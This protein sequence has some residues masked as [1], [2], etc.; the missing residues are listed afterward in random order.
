MKK[1]LIVD[2][3]E[4]NRYLMEVVLKGCGWE[5]VTTVNGVEALA[6]AR[7]DP[8]DIVISDILMP[9]MDGFTL[10]REWKADEV[11][12]HIPFVFYTATYTDSRDETFALSLGADRFIR[13]PQEP[14]LF[15]KIIKEVLGERYTTASGPLGADMEIFRQ[16]NEVL[17]RKL[18]KKV[19]DLESA[20]R[21]LKKWEE[22]YRLEFE[23]INDVIILLD[24]GLNI[25]SIS[26][27]LERMLGYGP[28]DF[29][30]RPISDLGN[31]V[32][33][34]VFAR[35]VADMNSILTGVRVPTTSC[36]F[37]AR[38]GTVRYGEISGSP[39]V[40]DG[41]IVGLIA[42]VR[43]ITERKQAEEALLRTNEL[44]DSIVENIPDMI[45]LKDAHDLRF[46]RFNRA[47][48]ELLGYSRD[49][50]LGKNDY[51][52]FSPEQADFFTE[53]DRRVLQGKRVVDI[54]EEPIRT[55]HRGE[56][57]LHTKKVP[58]LAADA[59][60]LYLLGISE[61]ITERKRALEA[62]AES[63]EKFRKAFNTT[64]DAVNINRLEDGLYVSINPGFTRITG[65]TEEDIIGR[66]SIECNIWVR[67]E[68]R[69]RLVEGLLKDGEVSNLEAVFRMKNG[70]IRSGLM[71]ASMIELNGV[72]HILNIT[73]DI[74][75]FMDM[76]RK[77]IHAQ[78]MEAIGTMAGGIAHDFNNVLMG[79]Q[80]YVSLI[81][82]NMNPAD[83]N[84]E[85]LRKI[86][87]QVQS[88]AGLSRQLLGFARGG[89]YELKP[90]NINEIIEKTVSIFS[91]TRKEIVMRRILTPDIWSV[92]VDRVQMEQ[93]FM[94][95]Y[96]N[97]W[98]AMPKG[99]EISLRTENF[100]V[101]DRQGERGVMIPGRYVKIEIADSGSGMDD[102]TR[103]RIFD[104]F[105][106][107]KDMGRGTGLGLAIVYGIIKAHK[108][109]V[110][111][112]SAPGQGTTFTVYLPASGKE[113][114]GETAPTETIAGG[115]E[116]ILLVDDEQMILEVSRELL[117][118]LGY[119]VYAAAGG[120]EAIALYRER[121]DEIDLVIL[122]MIM[123]GL[124]GG[125]T[126]DR[127][128]EINPDIKVL[129]ASGYSVSGEAEQILARGCNGFLQK[130]FQIEKL[131]RKIREV[132]GTAD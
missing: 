52:F 14:E 63:E 110:D 79:I 33:S 103:E 69:K 38:D 30:G 7:R 11:L 16:Y 10:C 4:Q 116:T 36:E 93:V 57:I 78:K 100:L 112:V 126:F 39:I 26:P 122:D 128:H 84:Y 121:K 65:Y 60:P 35:V 106:T 124:S 85:R 49:E 131:S 19:G 20:N 82:M 27:S 50:L 37:I 15:V 89:I 97:S 40:R 111:V 80:G 3:E 90:T 61:D 2:D 127:L 41:V 74:T 81:L 119:R 98:Q 6:S 47:G 64:P 109:V 43:D 101:E 46:V 95:L 5:T 58:I 32:R 23:N 56:R 125:E 88:G 76:E 24:T 9:G 70:E 86:E 53:M 132:L 77:L 1:C 87:E 115:R 108:G 104:P 107:T 28:Q 123:P 114:V 73:R 68:D 55:R 67:S 130:P 117:D 66:S 94:N 113:V 17:F 31:I 22:K 71:S 96:V 25:L 92:E 21:N 29:T 129:L 13:K 18:E 12:K 34:E 102:K 51:D 75:E 42:V 105:F 83:P 54:P 118:S 91:R 48:E 72:P 120:Q 62:L 99:G 8:P 44:L 45:F 59:R